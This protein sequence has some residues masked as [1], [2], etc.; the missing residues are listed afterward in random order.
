MVAIIH[1]L[2]DV[3]EQVLRTAD[4]LSPFYK[5]PRN[6]NDFQPNTMGEALIAGPSL[7]RH[8]L[9]F[10]SHTGHDVSMIVLAA[11]AGLVQQLAEAERV[12]ASI[13]HRGTIQSLSRNI[14][15]ETL[16]REIL[17]LNSWNRCENLIACDDGQYHIGIITEEPCRQTDDEVWTSTTL[18][19]CILTLSKVLVQPLSLGSDSK[20]IPSD[21]AIP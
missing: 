2:Q 10:C 14:T 16:C 15:E 20:C 8:A 12:S 13:Q 3:E 6:E 4:P 18:V 21:A 1:A 7:M 19:G 11:W 17:D 9:D 5:S